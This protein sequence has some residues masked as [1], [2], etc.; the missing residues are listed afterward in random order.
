VLLIA[1]PAFLILCDRWKDMTPLWRT[2][3]AISIATISFTIFDVVGRTLYQ[4]AM[5]YN[6]LTVATVLLLVC[7]ANLRFR[8][9][10]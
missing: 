10:A 4:F 2:L 1:T 6:V 8:K 5:K 9:I 3:T 7:L